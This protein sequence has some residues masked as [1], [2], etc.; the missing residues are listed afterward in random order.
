M[1]RNGINM[2]YLGKIIKLTQLPYVRV[3]GE[4]EA[5]ARVARNLYREHQREFAT[6]HFRSDIMLTSLIDEAFSR[7]TNPS[8][9]KIRIK[10]LKQEEDLSL[11][12]I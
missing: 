6:H 7:D 8:M 1:K 10:Q 3:M 12:H 4:I 11:I 9:R 5:I 2:R